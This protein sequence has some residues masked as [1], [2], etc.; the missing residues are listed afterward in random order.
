MITAKG[1]LMLGS[2]AVIISL[3]DMVKARTK[4][5]EMPVI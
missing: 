5:D 2:I 4:I 3:R 1:E